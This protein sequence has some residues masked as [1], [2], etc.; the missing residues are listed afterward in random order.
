MEYTIDTFIR[1]SAVEELIETLNNIKGISCTL[2]V[3]GFMN[4]TLILSFD[5]D[6]AP[7][8]ILHLGSLIGTTLKPN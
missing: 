6:P 2:E 4:R 8:D 1:S 7:E 3:K 5:T